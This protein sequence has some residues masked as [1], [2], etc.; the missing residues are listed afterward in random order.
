MN[1]APTCGQ[2]VILGK[3]HILLEINEELGVSPNRWMLI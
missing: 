2:K 3:Y 1:V